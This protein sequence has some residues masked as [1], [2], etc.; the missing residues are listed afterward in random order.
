MRDAQWVAYMTSA[1]RNVVGE[2]LILRSL[3]VFAKQKSSL[4]WEIS[5]DV[6]FFFFTLRYMGLDGLENYE[7]LEIVVMLLFLVVLPS[8]SCI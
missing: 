4:K 5:G 2:G 1:R 8:R 7:I 6:V 3:Y